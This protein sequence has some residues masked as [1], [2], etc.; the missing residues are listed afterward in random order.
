MRLEQLC[1]YHANIFWIKM[2]PNQKKN[3]SEKGISTSI[4]QNFQ[5]QELNTKKN[6]GRNMQ[7]NVRTVPALCSL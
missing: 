5:R 1:K 3:Y 6:G 4:Q 7:I 2:L